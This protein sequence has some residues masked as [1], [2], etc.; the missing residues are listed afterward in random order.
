MLFFPRRLSISLALLLLFLFGLDDQMR[1]QPWVYIYILFFLG[2]TFNIPS[3]TRL[4]YC[5]LILIS[6]YLWSGIH[7]ISP[8]F[9]NHVFIPLMESVF[10]LHLPKYKIIGY[11]VSVMEISIAIGLFFKVTQRYS[12]F[13][14]GILHLIILLW[15]S[16]WGNNTNYVIIPWNLAMMG[17]S[18]LCFYRKTE[19]SFAQQLTRMPFRKAHKALLIVFFLLPLLSYVEKWP[20]YFSFHLYSG[21]G[22]TLSVAYKKVPLQVPEEYYQKST[23]SPEFKDYKV[24]NLN[25]WSY[26]ELGVP[27]PS[28]HHIFHQLSTYFC[29]LSEKSEPQFLLYQTINYLGD[30]DVYSCGEFDL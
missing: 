11:G 25:K 19:W 3:S 7:K 27:V 24:I 21:K 1:W 26:L 13:A 8:H 12:F 5:R 29:R 14:L 4:F 18:Y 9:V 22:Q 17:L 10:L 15:V 20:Y 28:N 30:Y 16:P 23:N 6:I 2:F